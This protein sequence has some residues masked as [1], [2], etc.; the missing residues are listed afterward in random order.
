[1]C[2]LGSQKEDTA[3]P[4]CLKTQKCSTS[5]S[6]A[7]AS[8]LYLHPLLL[9]VYLV[10]LMELTA[11][12]L[13]VS[14]AELESPTASSIQGMLQMATNPSEQV[15]EIGDA[16]NTMSGNRANLEVG[17]LGT[18]GTGLGRSGRP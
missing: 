10:S 9:Q 5:S 14:V 18:L 1:M 4:S 8:W 3:V 16:L 17:W 15:Q 6:G 7:T 13:G 2:V 12:L 11:N